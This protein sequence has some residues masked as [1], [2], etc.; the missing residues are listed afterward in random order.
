MAADFKNPRKV[1][2]LHAQFAEI[3]E[4]HGFTL[5]SIEFHSWGAGHSNTK[6]TAAIADKTGKDLLGY[7]TGKTP[8][9]AFS[10]AFKLAEEAFKLAEAA[11]AAK[12]NNESPF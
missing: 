8:S 3:A 9:L 7:A 10:E 4:I 6:W 2:D 1:N 12:E 5:W 11:P